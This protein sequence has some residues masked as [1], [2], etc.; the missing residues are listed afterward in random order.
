[1]VTTMSSS[2]IRS[3]I[4]NSPWSAVIS[5]RRASPY[6]SATFCSSS[7]MMRMRR[8]REP[9]M[10]RRSLMRA[11]T[12]FSS[13]SSLSI[14]RPVSLARRMLRI[15][16]AWRSLSL[17]RRWSCALAVGG[18]ADDLDDRV[19]VIDGDLEPLEDVLAVE[20]LVEVELRAA[21]DDVVPVRDVVLQHVL[22]RHHLRH[23]L[24]GVR[25]GDERQ[26]DDAE[27]RLQV[28]VLVELVQHD[29][30]DRVAL[31]LDHDPHA[32]AVR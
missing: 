12:S 8:S 3:S 10:S 11:R 15:A 31:Q 21:D 19:D 4:V 16:S 1:M 5:V 17:N 22:E 32:V 18:G 28:G 26:H 30:R 27:R 13:A 24:P 9:R 2:A 25:V 14:S 23:E 20:R 7:F 6:V 29:A